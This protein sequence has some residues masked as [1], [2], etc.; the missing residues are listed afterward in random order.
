MDRLPQLPT[1]MI[2]QILLCLQVRDLYAAYRTCRT[3]RG[4]IQHCLALRER[5]FCAPL[6]GRRV[7]NVDRS[8]RSITLQRQIRRRDTHM[9]AVYLGNDLLFQ[10]RTAR[11]RYAPGRSGFSC[12]ALQFSARRLRLAAPA[13]LS[14][15]YLTQ[16]PIT[17]CAIQLEGVPTVDRLP[18]VVE[19]EGG[20]TLGELIH[21]IRYINLPAIALP[22]IIVSIEAAV[23]LGWKDYQA[24]CCGR[25]RDG[26]DRRWEPRCVTYAR[27]QAARVNAAMAA[28]LGLNTA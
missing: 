25:W 26:R 2:S 7:C 13:S 11:G 24:L 3:L 5:L 10:Q 16:P 27:S 23:C 14:S 28:E 9:C 19:R 1:E 8:R 18:A 17:R 22:R 6:M 4:C 21:A 15:M 12:L 20:V